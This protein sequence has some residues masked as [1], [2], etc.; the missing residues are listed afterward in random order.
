MCKHATEEHMEYYKIIM[1]LGVQCILPDHITHSHNVNKK[2]GINSNLKF[3]NV[4]IKQCHKTHA[5]EH[6]V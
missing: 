3:A 2:G 5:L 1:L 6:I 4:L